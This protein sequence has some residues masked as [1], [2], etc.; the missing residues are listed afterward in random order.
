M[1]YVHVHGDLGK[2]VRF[3]RILVR[4]KKKTL[5]KQKLTEKQLFIIYKHLHLHSNIYIYIHVSVADTPIRSDLQKCVNIS[6]YFPILIQQNLGQEHNHLN[7]Q[8]GG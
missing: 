6:E 1:K 8:M 7:T 5:T 2:P 3:H 4:T